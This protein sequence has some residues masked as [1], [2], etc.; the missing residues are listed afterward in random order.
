MDDFELSTLEQGNVGTQFLNKIL[1]EHA[2]T[3]AIGPE[4]TMRHR[5]AYEKESM[6]YRH[7][8]SRVKDSYRSFESA[9]ASSTNQQKA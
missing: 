2:S 6:F 1:K 3:I 7:E 4:I 8:E 5:L 9:K